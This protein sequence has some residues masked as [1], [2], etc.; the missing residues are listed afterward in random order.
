MAKWIVIFNSF[1][2]S[3]IISQPSCVVRLLAVL[4]AFTLP[5]PCLPRMVFAL[6]CR[7]TFG[8]A[9]RLHTA[10][11]FLATHGFCAF[12]LLDIYHIYSILRLFFVGIPLFVDTISSSSHLTILMSFSYFHCLS[13]ASWLH[14]IYPHVPESS[15]FIYNP[16]PRISHVYL[17]ILRALGWLVNKRIEIFLG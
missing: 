17:Y 10:I 9:C 16:W 5:S 6:L 4:V 3:S 8:R 12:S 11:A 2:I 7:S 14:Y 1:S 15:V 13:D